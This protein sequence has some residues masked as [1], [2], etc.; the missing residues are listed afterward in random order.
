[1]LFQE[2][3]PGGVRQLLKRIHLTAFSLRDR[4][5][6]DT[7]RLLNRLE[8]DARRRAGRLPLA[9]ASNVLHTLVL[10]LAAFS[11]MEM[12]NMTRATAG[13]PRPS[14]AASSELLRCGAHGSRLRGGADSD[15]L[16]EPAWNRRQRE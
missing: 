5:S 11:G 4:L 14:A 1:L 10:D 15:P 7:W 16:L 8:P 6:A 9:G 3:K 13:L 12:E 2:E